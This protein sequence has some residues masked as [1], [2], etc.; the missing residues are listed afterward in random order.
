MCLVLQCDGVTGRGLG[1]VGYNGGAW[2]NVRRPLTV[3]VGVR[4]HMRRVLASC[5]CEGVCV[6]C[7]CSVCV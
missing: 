6:V 1:R 5:V 4:V 3:F 2:K 7:V